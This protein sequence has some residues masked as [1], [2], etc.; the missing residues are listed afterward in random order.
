MIHIKKAY[1]YCSTHCTVIIRKKNTV[2]I[3]AVQCRYL[4]PLKCDITDKCS[5]AYVLLLLFRSSGMDL[6]AA[7]QVSKFFESIR[8][9]KA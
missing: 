7:P 3:L 5:V 8:A 1:A 2:R 6:Q 9:H 4:V